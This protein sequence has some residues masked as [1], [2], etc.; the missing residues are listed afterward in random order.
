[1][2]ALIHIEFYLLRHILETEKE[3]EIAAKFL[4]KWLDQVPRQFK[5][6]RLACSLFFLVLIASFFF[7]F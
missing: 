3:I 1:M 2:D 7:K 5:P 6:S 4:A